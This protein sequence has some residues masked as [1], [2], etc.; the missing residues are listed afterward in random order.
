MNNASISYKPGIE[1][2]H[3]HLFNFVL[4]FETLEDGK[5]DLSKF[6]RI[7]VIDFDQAQSS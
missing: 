5:P 6:P 7:Y 3:L 2:G 4:V 1:H